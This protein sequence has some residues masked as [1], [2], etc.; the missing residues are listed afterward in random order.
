MF[1]HS[2]YIYCCSCWVLLVLP[3]EECFC[4]INYPGAVSPRCRSTDST[5]LFPWPWWGFHPHYPVGVVSCS[6]VLASL[7]VGVSVSRLLLFFIL[8]FLDLP[9]P[10]G[11]Y[12]DII[13][14]SLRL[15]YFFHCWIYIHTFSLS[16]RSLTEI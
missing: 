11:N 9:K 1:F 7:L 5:F 3:V 10:T 4:W 16:E 6:V 8:F 15:S 12:Y 2:I 13:Y 14:Q